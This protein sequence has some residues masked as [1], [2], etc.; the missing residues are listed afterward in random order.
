LVLLGGMFIAVIVWLWAVAVCWQ[1]WRRQW[2]NCC[3]KWMSCN[4]GTS[5]WSIL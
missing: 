2:R 5:R 4:L 1:Y 3:T